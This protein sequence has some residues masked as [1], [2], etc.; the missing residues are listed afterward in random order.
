MR[1]VT[2]PVVIVLAV[3]ACTPDPQGEHP[4]SGEAIPAEPGPMRPPEAHM[5][6]QYAL[7]AV[8]GAPLPAVLDQDQ[9][10]R[11]EIVDAALRVEA[12]RFAFQNR[13]REV[14]APMETAEPVMHAAGGAVRIDGSLVILDT[15]VGQAFAQAQ[16]T[17]DETGIMLQRL[18][19]DAG[20]III[21]WLFERHGPQTVPFPGTEDR[22]Q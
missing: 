7:V 19:T 20:T 22:T 21:N 13:V 2:V 14:C 9:R 6:G 10:C 3:A 1:R 5:E 4:A 15:D 11:T 12:G 17:A 16:G 8:D 18:S